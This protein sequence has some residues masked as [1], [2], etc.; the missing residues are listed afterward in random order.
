MQETWKE[1]I[2]K[3]THYIDSLR[4]LFIA[5]WVL[6]F[7]FIPSLVVILAEQTNL[8]KIPGCYSDIYDWAELLSCKFWQRVG[9]CMKKKVMGKR[10]VTAELC[11]S[12]GWHHNCLWRG[13]FLT[14]HLTVFILDV[15]TT[16]DKQLFLLIEKMCPDTHYRMNRWDATLLVLIKTPQTFMF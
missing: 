9:F 3:R 5:K 10:V 16:T 12:D 15:K 1:L 8:P 13:T 11:G 6:F 2:S 7:I 4:D 14:Q